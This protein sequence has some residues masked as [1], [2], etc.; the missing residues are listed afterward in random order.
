[1]SNDAQPPGGD[2]ASSDAGGGAAP[3]ERLSN[4]DPRDLRHVRDYTTLRHKPGHVVGRAE[5]HFIREHFDMDAEDVFN[6]LRSN[7]LKN[8]YLL[9]NTSVPKAF[10]QASRAAA[11]V[12]GSSGDGS[13]LWKPC[14]A[15]DFRNKSSNSGLLGEPPTLK[16]RLPAPSLARANL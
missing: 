8:Y 12:K 11:S 10:M 5:L 16:T 7:P 15:P 13:G 3:I 1:M 2:K 14:F 9:G 4:N 6:R